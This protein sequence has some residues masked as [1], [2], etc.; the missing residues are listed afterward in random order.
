MNERQKEQ[1]RPTI[2]LLKVEDLPERKI[3]VFGGLEVTTDRGRTTSEVD[4]D[5]Y[6]PIP[7]LRKKIHIKVPKGSALQ[8]K[9]REKAKKSKQKVEERD[10]LKKQRKGHRALF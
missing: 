1:K 8:K 2:E 5:S 7:K 9:V 3:P 10:F 6:I 4:N